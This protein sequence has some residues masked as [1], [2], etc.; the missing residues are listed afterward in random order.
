M[1]INYNNNWTNQDVTV[2]LIATD[3]MSSVSILNNNGS[4]TYTFTQNGEFT[5]EFADEAGNVAT[6][7]A[8]VSRIDKTPP[9][10]EVQ[11]SITTITNT[12]VMA[13]VSANEPI[14]V[15][16]NGGSNR[17]YF[18]ENGEFTFGVMD[19]AGNIVYVTA[20]VD[21]IDKTPP[22]PTL[23]YSTTEITKDD[24]VVTVGADEEF[25]VLNNS[26]RTQR[27]FTENGTFTFY[28]QDIVGNVAEIEAVVN[29]IDKSRAI[30]TLEYSETE[31]TQNDV[32]VTI[33]SDRPITVQN[34]DGTDGEGNAYVMFTQNGTRWINIKDNLGNETEIRINVT[35]IDR[36]KPV[37]KFLEGEMLIIQQGDQVQPL[38]DIS[39]ID[40]L[41]GDMLSKVTVTHNINANVPG[42]YT[43]TYTVTDRAGNT[44]SVVRNAKVVH[45]GEFS[46][47]INSRLPVDGEVLVEGRSIGIKV[48]GAKGIYTVKWAE[49]KK[50]EGAFKGIKNFVEDGNLP[51]SRSGY[52]TIFVQDQ[53]RQTRLIHVY[54]MYE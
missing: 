39:V 37:I 40:N 17:Y 9:V 33:K 6:A 22:K 5:F 32:T 30:I 26:R 42:E 43:V 36:E 54:V 27:V 24:V 19:R 23:T 50:S 13:T 7:T 48:L 47:F 34:A 10:V 29:N 20:S 35:N 28:I 45:A 46:V 14:S 4:D 1:Y 15:I 3:D 51:V 49:G 41:D 21:W 12:D 53:E 52:Y 25:I 44:T 18:T 2:R 38:A 31:P 8:V 16:N 11:Y